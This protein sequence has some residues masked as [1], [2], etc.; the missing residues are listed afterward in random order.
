MDG[1][2]LFEQWKKELAGTALGDE[3]AALTDPEEIND[4][5]Y[6]IL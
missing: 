5:F 2:A 3:L 4:R 6:R 1:N